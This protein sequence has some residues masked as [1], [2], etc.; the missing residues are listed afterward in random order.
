M[1][2]GLKWENI[3]IQQIRS[4]TLHNLTAL[5]YILIY[6]NQLIF[7]FSY[8]QILRRGANVNDRD[9]LTDMSMLHYACKA[10]AGMALLMV[11]VGF[12]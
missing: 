11:P 9:G 5:P 7:S 8:F 10:G 1:T 4:I 6:I 12:Q 2:C 3:V